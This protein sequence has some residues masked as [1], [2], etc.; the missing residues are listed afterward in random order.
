MVRL[1]GLERPRHPITF[2]DRVDHVGRDRDRGALDRPLASPSGLLEPVAAC[3]HHDAVEPRLEAGGFTQRSVLRPGR[4]HRVMDGILRFGT[5]T[6]DDASES[7][8]PIQVFV[9]Q[10]LEARD[11]V[12][13]THP[14][15]SVR[16]SAKGLS[17]ISVRASVTARV[18]VWSTMT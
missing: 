15:A 9:T 7:V 14:R 1:K 12:E 3:I 11:T 2:V 16:V 17:A 8:A 6:E 10:T 13:R 4:H 18:L 5:V